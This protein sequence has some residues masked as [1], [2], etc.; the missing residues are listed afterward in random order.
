MCT[1]LVQTTAQKANSKVQSQNNGHRNVENSKCLPKL[2][3]VVFLIEYIQILV[4]NISRLNARHITL[5]FTFPKVYTTLFSDV[6]TRKKERMYNKM[7]R[8][9]IKDE[10]S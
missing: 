3:R 6:Y 10:K 1:H 9:N 8:W 5:Y 2:A 4:Q 7:I